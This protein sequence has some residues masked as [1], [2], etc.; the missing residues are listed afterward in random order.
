MAV[1]LKITWAQVLDLHIRPGGKVGWLVFFRSMIS[2]CSPVPKMPQGQESRP[3]GLTILSLLWPTHLTLAF[4]ILSMS[5]K[6]CSFETGF[7]DLK[8]VANQF[9]MFSKQ[10]NELFLIPLSLEH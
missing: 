7:C 4:Y 1:L 6:D 10:N 2:R 8:T 3:T 5:A 9:F